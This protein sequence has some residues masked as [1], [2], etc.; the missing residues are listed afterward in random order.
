MKASTEGATTSWPQPCPECK[1][2][3]NSPQGLAAHRRS[4][5]GVPGKNAQT[6]KAKSKRKPK[7]KTVATLDMVWSNKDGRMVLLDSENNLWFARKVE[8]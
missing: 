3:M 6:T 5:H 7:A 1:E 8:V 2:P 4:K